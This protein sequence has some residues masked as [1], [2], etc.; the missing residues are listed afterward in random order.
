MTT[1]A[2]ISKDVPALTLDGRKIWWPR[3]MLER[4]AVAH[5]S[6]PV[7]TVARIIERMAEAVMDTREMIPGYITE[8]PEFKEIGERMM[9]VWK[10]GV[11][12]VA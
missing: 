1:T 9:A 8:H 2:Y 12:G 4:F 7:G 5:L 3:R 10:E 11:S 6:L